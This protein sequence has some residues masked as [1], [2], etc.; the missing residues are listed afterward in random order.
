MADA[1]ALSRELRQQGQ[2]VAPLNQA[3]ESMR[4][5]TS[6]LTGL[7]DKK[8]E[9]LLRTQVIEGLKAYEFNLR[10]AN[11]DDAGTRVLLERTGDV[12]PAYK[13]MVEEYYRSLSRPNVKPP[14][15]PPQ[16]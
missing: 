13:A 3:I 15:K 2:D 11:G 12:P 16:P 4:N 6:T 8:A 7:D 10:R 1:E 9:A 14:A 5:M